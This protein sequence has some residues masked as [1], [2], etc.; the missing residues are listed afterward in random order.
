MSTK[1]TWWYDD[2]E[3]R[4][5]VSWSPGPRCS[6]PWHPCAA[7]PSTN[8]RTVHNWSTPCNASPVLPKQ[9]VQGLLGHET[10][11]PPAW[12]WNKPL[13]APNSDVLVWLASLCIG[14]CVWTIG[15]QT[16]GSQ[17]GGFCSEGCLLQ[18]PE[19]GCLEWTFWRS[20]MS[21]S[22]LIP[23]LHLLISLHAVFSQK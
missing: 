16:P 22:D 6:P 11:L 15:L 23:P 13:S 20:C 4:V 8:Q 19:R 14:H 9:R 18:L 2:H 12:P 21:Q 7:A 3:H 17:W 1:Q 5:T 10:P